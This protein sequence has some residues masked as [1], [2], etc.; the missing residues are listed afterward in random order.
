VIGSS[1]P[2][3]Q[4][5]YSRP[6]D[7]AL[8]R[9]SM[10]GL[11]HRF[12]PAVLFAGMVDSNSLQL[13]E[14]LGT[15]TTSL[16]KVSVEPGAGLGGRV[17]SQH[18]PYLVTDYLTS[19]RITHE[20]DFAVHNERIQSLA[21][22]PIIVRGEPRSVLYLG[23]RGDVPLGQRALQDAMKAAAE[24]AAEIQIRDE[25]DRR[26]SVISQARAENTGGSDRTWL[27]HVRQAHAELRSLATTVA[28][29]KLAQQLSGI[30]SRLAPS[31][32]TG[33]QPV[34]RLAP[35]ELDVLAQ[36]AMG[37]SYQETADRLGLKAVTVKSYLQNAM[38]KLSAHNRL[39]AVSI[40]RRLGLLP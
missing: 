31:S 8:L 14:F 36:L 33:T 3:Q 21:A 25:V 12:R 27:E 5:E 17:F 40:A 9:A 20:Y 37:C 18:R 7:R 6:D 15:V 1:A 38:T 4:N 13:S 29:V 10:R 11:A 39:E 32:F 19:D 22:V 24:I 2:L 23:S 26:V 30:S 28:D 16:H 35:R 34:L